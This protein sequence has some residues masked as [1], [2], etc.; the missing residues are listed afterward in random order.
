[1]NHLGISGEEN[2]KVSPSVSYE[3][4]YGYGRGKGKGGGYD[5]RA[6][7]EIIS[8]KLTGDTKIFWNL[9]DEVGVENAFENWGVRESISLLF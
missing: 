4:V 2:K 9:G 7:H 3:R 1:M 6:G 5:N 8:E